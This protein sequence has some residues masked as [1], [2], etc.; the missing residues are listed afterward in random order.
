MNSSLMNSSQPAEGPDLS[1]ACVEMEPYTGSVCTDLLTSLQTCYSGVT[2]P[3]TG[4]NIPSA[5]VPDQAA[6]EQSAMTLLGGL[7]FFMPT[8]ECAAAITPF[9]CLANFPL[10][11]ADDQVHIILREACLELR[12]DIC[13]PQ[14]AAA[15]DRLGASAL[16]VCEALPDLSE[17]CVGTLLFFLDSERWSFSPWKKKSPR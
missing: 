15:L 16:P 12:D 17:E 14:W 6:A 9:I 3:P 1:M 2:S 11:D 13:A 5:L 7:P 4:L 8:P 10:C